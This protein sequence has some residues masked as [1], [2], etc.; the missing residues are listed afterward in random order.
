[1][2]EEK[3]ETAPCTCHIDPNTDKPLPFRNPC[4]S[5]TIPGL[6]YQALDAGLAERIVSDHNTMLAIHQRVEKETKS[7]GTRPGEVLKWLVTTGYTIII[8]EEAK[9]VADSEKGM[10][11][12]I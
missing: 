7:K 1:M 9:R 5:L 11:R 4:S 6:F 12:G 8:D 3:W 10:Q 2:L